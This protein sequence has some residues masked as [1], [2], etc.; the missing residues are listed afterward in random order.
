MRLARE[1]WPFILP[2]LV[3][4]LALL[5]LGRPLGAAILFLVA[6]A[7]ALFFRDPAR[8]FDGPPEVLLAPADG[9]I[10]AVDEIDAAFAGGERRQR[11]ITFLSVFDVHV[12]RAP[13]GGEVVASKLERGAVVAACRPEAGGIEE[14]RLPVI[15]TPGGELVG[16]VQIAGRLARR[17]VG[18]LDV[19]DRIGRGEHLGLIKF[20]SRVDLILPPGCIIEVGP[21]D[22]VV[23]GQT[24]MARL[25]SA[26]DGPDDATE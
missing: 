25:P 15:R 17:G 19:G 14:R 18:Y 4:A 13:V 22:R 5:A 8:R 23:A 3:A 1:G 2:S 11:I 7:T 16:V 6:I 26:T 20:G 24:P 21:G 10:L 12:Q 9:K